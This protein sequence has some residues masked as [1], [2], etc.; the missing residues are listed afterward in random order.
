MPSGNHMMA[1]STPGR[2]MHNAKHISSSSHRIGMKKKSTTHRDTRTA[3]PGRAYPSGGTPSVGD[4]E[5]TVKRRPPPCAGPDS[6]T[7]SGP[8]LTPSRRTRVAG[9]PW[10]SV[11][12]PLAVR[13][14]GSR[15]FPV[16]ALHRDKVDNRA[17]ETRDEQVEMIRYISSIQTVP[18]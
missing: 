15:S 10:S 2:A 5:A 12:G 7:P 13:P 18:R 4:R 9:H 1:A 8:T 16:E 17:S 6:D 14:V 11:V 3:Y